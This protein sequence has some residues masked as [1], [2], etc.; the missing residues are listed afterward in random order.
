MSIFPLRLDDTM[1]RFANAAIFYASDGFRPDQKGINGRRVAGESFLNGFLKHAKVEEF[2]FLTKTTREIE[3]IKG[4]YQTARPTKRMRVAGFLKPQEIAPVEVVYYPAANIGAEAWRRANYGSGAWALCG[5]THTTSTPAIMQGFFD[6]RM[7]PVMEWDAV[8]C[9]S[10]AVQGS[11]LA[12]MD[13]IDAHIR[14]R[15]GTAPPDARCSP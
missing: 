12:Q 7:A 4:F 9:T 5:L 8:I 14:Q 1:T 11:V 6:L 13:L 15:F 3:E 2:V 10:R